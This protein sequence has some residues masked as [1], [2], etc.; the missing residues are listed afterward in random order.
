MPEMLIC[1]YMHCQLFHWA[2]LYDVYNDT[3][4]TDAVSAVCFIDLRISTIGGKITEER[5][6][7][8]LP[9]LDRLNCMVAVKDCMSVCVFAF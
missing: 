6:V 7:Y 8:Q 5:I 2:L 9:W 1:I 3:L 4:Y